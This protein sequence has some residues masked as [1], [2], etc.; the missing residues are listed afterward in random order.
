MPRMRNKV[1]LI[2]GATGGIGSATARLFAEE[3]ARL[4][5]ADLD[6]G[7]VD[8]LVEDITGGGA[9]AIGCVLDVSDASSWEA[10]VRACLDQFGTLT[11]LVNVAGIVAW[12]GVEDTDEQ[13]WDRVIAV[14]QTGTW[15]GMRAALPALR[16]SADASIVN[17][18]SVLGII[19]GGGAAAY[20]ASKGAVR[21]LTKT[22]AVEYATLGVRVNSIHP[23]VIAT[24]MI[25]E[26]L[27][28]EGDEQRDIA[29]T[30]MKR[31]G[32]AAEIAAGILF[33]ASDES[34]FVT[35]AE[36]VVDG[37]LTAH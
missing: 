20:H 1:A 9:E 8:A 30:P 13:T 35:G 11:T 32:T 24:P 37:G 33:L 34:S 5:V 28:L 19:G 31:A 36:L 17:T 3:G 25:Q 14:N 29:R 23:G 16:A 10:A 27:D 21:L 6:R 15:L 18:S 7:A 12:P 26:I 22:A 2:S 4:V